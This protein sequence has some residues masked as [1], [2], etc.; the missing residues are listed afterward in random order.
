MSG[1]AVE[2]PALLGMK[3]ITVFCLRGSLESRYRRHVA[4]VVD[5]TQMPHEEMICLR[6][7]HAGGILDMIA[8]E[9]V[10]LHGHVAQEVVVDHL[11]VFLGQA[12]LVSVVAVAKVVAATADPDI[13]AVQIP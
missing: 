2:F 12:A 7:P 1:S 3:T 10:T 11:A 9:L 8:P 13:R 5:T 4:F 6:Q